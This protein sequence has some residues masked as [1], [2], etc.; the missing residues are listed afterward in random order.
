MERITKLCA[1]CKVK[2]VKRNR[3]T[4]CSYDCTY[5][6]KACG[7]WSNKYW[8]KWLFEF[9]EKYGHL[10]RLDQLKIAFKFGQR[11]AYNQKNRKSNVRVQTF[12][13]TSRKN[14]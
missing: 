9:D 11:V 2:K 4:Y 7:E 8:R 14:E 6:A 3:F 5:K 12:R 10:D 13:R 1:Y